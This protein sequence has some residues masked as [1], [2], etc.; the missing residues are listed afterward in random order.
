MFH[1]PENFYACPVQGVASR[2]ISVFSGQAS[3]VSQRDGNA[4]AI[5]E[6]AKNYQSLFV[7]RLRASAITLIACHIPLVVHRP[8]DTRAVSQSA[9]DGEALRVYRARAVIVSLQL[10]DI[11]QVTESPC[12]R[13]LVAEFPPQRQTCFEQDMRSRD[14]TPVAGKD[15]QRVQRDCDTRFVTQLTRAVLTF[16]DAR[17]RRSVIS[18]FAGEDARGKK[19]AHAQLRGICRSGKLQQSTQPV[20]ALGEV[21]ANLPIT[22]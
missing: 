3:Q 6:L 22:K 10:E 21:L 5:A 11:G 2:I 14:I 9:E 19:R 15:R 7:Q 13:L 17:I 8:S 18:L 20:S 4:P 1:F 12:N 16:I